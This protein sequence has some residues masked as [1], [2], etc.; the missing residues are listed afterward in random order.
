MEVTRRVVLVGLG[1]AAVLGAKPPHPPK[2]RRDA[3]ARPGLVRGSVTVPHTDVRISS[4]S[5]GFPDATNMPSL[6]GSVLT[7]YPNY[8]TNATPSTVTLTTSGTTSIGTS[9]QTLDALNFTNPLSVANTVTNTH[10]TRCAFNGQVSTGGGDPGNATATTFTDCWINANA[11]SLTDADTPTAVGFS[12]FSMLRC[13]VFNSGHILAIRYNHT[14]KDCWLH[15]QGGA[16]HAHKD[17]IFSGGGHTVLI[18]HCTFDCN[19]GSD[20]VTACIGFLDDFE[21][22]TDTVVQNCL[23]QGVTAALLYASGGPAKPFNTN[24][25]TVSG[26]HFGT[27]YAIPV[28]VSYF[29]SGQP[30]NVWGSGNVWHDGPNAGTAVPPA[31]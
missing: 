22:Q 11:P 10:F 13:N 29:D 6:S 28:P 8:P 31:Y 18:D 7:Y 3:L 16:T 21:Q 1:A 27:K 4:A 25:L 19:D 9:N 14:I 5:P 2:R 30:S 26:N 20:G 17:G 24:G 23:L 15:G 12:D